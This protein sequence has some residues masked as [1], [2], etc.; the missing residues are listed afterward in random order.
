M[1]F[2]RL[3]SHDRYLIDR[4]AT[5]V[6]ELREGRLPKVFKGSYREFV[7]RRA[8]NAAPGA[9]R[10]ARPPARA[11]VRLDSRAARKKAESLALVEEAVSRK[12]RARCSACTAP[13]SRL[14]RRRPLKKCAS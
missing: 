5:Q 9:A 8:A 12:R 1:K 10:Q 13:S 6:W 7:L 2:L 11:Q 14:A 3:V 4:M